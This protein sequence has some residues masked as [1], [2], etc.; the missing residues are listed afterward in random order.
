MLIRVALGITCS[1]PIVIEMSHTPA[2]P[3]AN[4]EYLRALKDGL[5]HIDA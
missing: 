5:W 1:W 4:V 2:V 3:C